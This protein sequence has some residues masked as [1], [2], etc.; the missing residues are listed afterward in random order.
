MYKRKLLSTLKDR[1]G[2]G[3]AIVLLGPRQVGKTTLIET[4]LKKHDHLFLDA[5]DPTVFELLSN[6]NTAQLATI[7]GNHKVVFIDEAQ[8]LPN[9]GIT[10]KLITDQFKHVQLLVS[11]SSSFE[12]ANQ[13]NE[14]LTGRKWQY[15]LYPISWEEIENTEG[16]VKAIQQ[17]EL[18]LIYGS[19]PDVL[20]NKNN[21]QE[22]LQELSGSYLYK[23]I[24]AFSGIRKPEVLEKLLQALAFQVG[25]EVSY[26]ELA[27]TVGVD[28][29]TIASYI[30]LLEQGFVIFSLKS[31]SRNLRNEIKRNRKI[32]FYDVGLRNAVIGN[33]SPLDLRQDIGALWENFLIVE[34]L[35]R[36]QYYKTAGRGYFW[37]TIGQQEIDYVEEKNGVITG[38]EFKWNAKAKVKKHKKF[39]ES[40]HAEINIVNKENFRGFV[41]FDEKAK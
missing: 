17:L 24:L 36:N 37:R 16:F 5:D 21:A 27:Q 28:K 22:V 12:I 8:R 2:K 3:K 39:M 29:N 9:V 10:L 32:Y 26:N 11:G 40:Y 25:N 7:I 34:R 41:L 1:M 30:N 33:F 13:T 20:N 6:P 15:I 18:R 23:D 31:F 14:P 19:Y 4:L 38:Y 35:K